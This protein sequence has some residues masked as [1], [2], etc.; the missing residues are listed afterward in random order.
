[1]LTCD[2]RNLREPRQHFIKRARHPH[3]SATM[4]DDLRL[5]LCLI[6][7]A[8][9]RHRVLMHCVADAIDAGDEDK[10]GDPPP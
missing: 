8:D 2:A 4:K 9:Y 6:V 3:D 1:M 5:V 10:A 7:I